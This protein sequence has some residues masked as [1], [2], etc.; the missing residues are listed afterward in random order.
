[1]RLGSIAL[2]IALSLCGVAY[3]QR[4]DLTTASS[5]YLYFNR[6]GATLSRHNSELANC[7]LVW[8]TASSVDTSRTTQHPLVPGIIDGAIADAVNDQMVRGFERARRAVNVEH[9]MIARGWRLMALEER[10]GARLAALDDPQ[11]AEQLLTAIGSETPPGSEI[12]RWRNE[13]ARF[14]TVIFSSPRMRRQTLLSARVLRSAPLETIQL[15]EAAQVSEYQPSK[16]ARWKW[17]VSS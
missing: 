5:G 7:M 12:R 13:G 2:S 3:A 8:A 9:C 15:L 16:T 14:D 4:A 10:E 11:L 1:M 17:F 6:P